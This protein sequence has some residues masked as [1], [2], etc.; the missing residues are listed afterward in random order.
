[1]SDEAF[2]RTSDGWGGVETLLQQRNDA[3]AEVERLSEVANLLSCLEYKED[4][5]SVQVIEGKGALFWETL[6][7]LKCGSEKP[8]T[9][10]DVAWK[11]L[12]DIAWKGE[13]AL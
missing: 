3:L 6:Y 12:I 8:T 2:I 9:L 7:V 1:M 10:M 13:D 4:R 11:G 5:A